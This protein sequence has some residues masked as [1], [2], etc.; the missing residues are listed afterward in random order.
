MN[1]KG[2]MQM[3]KTILLKI[4]ITKQ[5]LKYATLKF[6][7]AANPTTKD[8]DA[9]PKQLSAKQGSYT[10]FYKQ[11]PMIV[12]QELRTRTSTQ[13]LEQI[14]PELRGKLLQWSQR[15]CRAAELN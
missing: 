14:R 3:F 1:Q 9:L 13:D 7:L 10:Y 6:H 4:I 12:V 15:H 2:Q 11:V 8:D 5:I